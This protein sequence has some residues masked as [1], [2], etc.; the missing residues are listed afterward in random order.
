MN[1]S[2]PKVITIKI[3]NT[4]DKEYSVLASQFSLSLVKET[5]KQVETQL[6]GRHAKPYEKNTGLR[7]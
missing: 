3:P 4:T 2:W 1:F 6:K 7:S 5:R